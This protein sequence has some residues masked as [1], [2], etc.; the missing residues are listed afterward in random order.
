VSDGFFRLGEQR[1]ALGVSVHCIGPTS[2][3]TKDKPL[4]KVADFR[5]L[6]M[7]VLATRIE[8][9]LMDRLGASGLPIPL[10]ETPPSL[11]NGMIDG[12]RS[13]IIVTAGLRKLVIDTAWEMS[14]FGYRQS[15]EIDRRAA[16]IWRDNGAEVI[17]W[18]REER[19]EF[20]RRGRAVA[21]AE[22]RNNPDA[23]TRELYLLLTETADRLRPKS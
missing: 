5:G 23:K 19:D 14:E 8:T 1:G 21:D 3:S 13:N 11:Q 17:V 10:E 12:I 22:L 16:Q 20:M 7:R 6:K 18:P 15:V 2:Y 9:G 4:R